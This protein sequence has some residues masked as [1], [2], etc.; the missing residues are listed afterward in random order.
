ML[1]DVERSGGVCVVCVAFVYH[2]IPRSLSHDDM[3]FV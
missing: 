3:F 1:E 2:M